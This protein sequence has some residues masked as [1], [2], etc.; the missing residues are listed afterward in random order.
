[1]QN[2]GLSPDVVTFICVLKACGSI[3]AVDKG[4]EIH[5]VIVNRGL[6]EKEIVLGNTLVYMYVKCGCIV[7]AL[8]VMEDLPVRNEVSWTAVIGGYAQLE[9]GHKALACYEKMQN[10]GISANAVTFISILKACASIGAIAK[11]EQIHKEIVERDLLAKGIMLG[12]AL[13]D[14]YAKCGMLTKAAQVLKGLPLRNVITWNALIAGYAQGGHG[15]EA[16]DCFERMQRESIA[17]DEITFLCILSACSHSGL[18]KEAEGLFSSMAEKYGIMPSAEHQACM[19]MVLAFAGLFS[20]AMSMVD[21]MPS[22]DFMEIW[23]AL[24]D[25]CRKWGNVK[26]GRLAFERAVQ[27]DSTC[28]APYVLM[29]SIYIAAGMPE[30]AQKVEAMKLRCAC[31]QR[32]QHFE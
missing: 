3:G 2:E 10:E 15:Q 30:H 26:H 19:A 16:L 13:V 20:K 24:L 17:P 28:A 8:K 12:N 22:Y 21:T 6:L 29:A 27:V 5:A 23:L 31:P 14:M 11:G 1:M 25:A 9:D 32:K 7:T 4:E 18:H